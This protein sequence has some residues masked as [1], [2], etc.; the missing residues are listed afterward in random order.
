[1]GDVEDTDTLSDR[2]VLGDDAAPAVLQR[3]RPSGEVAELHVCLD[4]SMMQG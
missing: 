3:H 1:V 4:V 2:Q